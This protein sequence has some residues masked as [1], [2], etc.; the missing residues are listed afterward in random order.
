MVEELLLET[1]EKMEKSIEATKEKFSHVRAG[2]ANVTMVDGVLVDYYGTMSPLNQ[3]GN[4]STPEARLIVIDPW[5]KSMIP[6]IEKAIIQANLGFNPSNDGKIIRLVVPELTEERRKEYVKIVK[7]E[8]EEGKVAV[9]NIRKDS[10]NKLRRL[11]K[12]HSITEDELK[13]AEEKI[14]KLTDKYVQLIDELLSKKEKE[15]T[16]I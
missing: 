1:E 8:A 4:L 16:K 14:Q 11:E 13:L 9:R 5:D 12:E 6:I 15:L 2:R 10:N 7:K 3:V